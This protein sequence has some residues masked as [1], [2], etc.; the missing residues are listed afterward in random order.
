MSDITINSPN[1]MP[2]AVNPSALGLPVDLIQKS[3]ARRET[4][5]QSPNL[6]LVSLDQL[7]NFRTALQAYARTKASCRLEDAVD[8]LRRLFL[9]NGRSPLL[10]STLLTSYRWLDPVNE[11]A[12]ADV[13]HMY[14]RAYGGIEK[15]SGV[16]NDIDTAPA[17]PLFPSDSDSDSDSD[18]SPTPDPEKPPITHI[19]LSSLNKELLI[20][21]DAEKHDDEE[22][23]EDIEAWYRQVYS[24]L[25]TTV[26][27]KPIPIDPLRSH[28]PVIEIPPPPPSPPPPP[29]PPAPTVSITP[30][31]A[32]AASAASTTTT[33]M[34]DPPSPERQQNSTPKLRPAPP[35]RSLA[36]KLQT[37]FSTTQLKKPVATRPTLNIPS[38]PVNNEDE[39][40]IETARPISAVRTTAGNLLPAVNHNTNNAR[41]KNTGSVMT[42]DQMLQGRAAGN[43]E[44]EGNS[45]EDNRVGPMTPNGYDDIS[46][47]TRGEWGFLMFGQARKGGVGVC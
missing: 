10:K 34:V 36:L 16:Q 22:E 24:T 8:E 41:W 3:L 7:Y 4:L 43:L 12:L 33:T 29:P 5:F 45:K 40:E 31:A 32:S 30:P 27:P 9:A 18:G 23:D 19:T 2:Q 46:P 37:S 20:S 28:P 47:I 1:W 21:S 17:W 39:E 14:E 25:P 13:C 42:I 44:V 6:T 35:G 38:S 15:E 26:I 11:A